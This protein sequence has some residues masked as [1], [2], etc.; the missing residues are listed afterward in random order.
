MCGG[1][2]GETSSERAL[3]LAD[4]SGVMPILTIVDV[5]DLRFSETPDWLVGV[6]TV[7]SVQEMRQFTRVQPHSE[8]LKTWQERLICILESRR[9]GSL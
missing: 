5:R 9:R 3:D 8:K 6:P 2:E 1:G 4:R 7:L